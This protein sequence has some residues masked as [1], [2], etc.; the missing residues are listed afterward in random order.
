MTKDDNEN[1]A[2]TNIMARTAQLTVTGHRAEI[3]LEA[4]ATAVQSLST[5]T[6]IASSTGHDEI[7]TT[8]KALQ[9][10][11]QSVFNI[12][13][14]NVT[15]YNFTTINIIEQQSITVIENQIE[16]YTA[17]LEA[18]NV[19]FFDCKDAFDKCM[20]NAADGG[21]QFHCKLLYSACLAK[22]GTSTLTPFL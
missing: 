8:G 9:G 5:A 6:E 20:S 15:I 10:S 4:S 14:S 22:Q 1:S 21:E 17:A 19:P 11:L 2:N 7:A 13:D 18:S 16:N 12:T 3:L